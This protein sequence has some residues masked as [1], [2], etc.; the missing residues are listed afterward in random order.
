MTIYDYKSFDFPWPFI[1]LT[2]CDIV[3]YSRILCMVLYNHLLDYM[4]IFDCVRFNYTL[5]DH[6]LIWMTLLESVSL[7][8]TL[9]FT[10]FEFVWLYL[11]LLIHVFLDWLCLNLFWLFSYFLIQLCLNLLKDVQLCLNLLLIEVVFIFGVSSFF[12]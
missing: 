4:T 2:L 6:V 7:T 5:Y 10:L 8:F 12:R 1:T 11:I 3:F 9:F